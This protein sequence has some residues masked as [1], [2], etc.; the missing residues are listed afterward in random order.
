MNEKTLKLNEEDIYTLIAGLA[1]LINLDEDCIKEFRDDGMD[2]AKSEDLLRK[3][4][5]LCR[6]LRELIA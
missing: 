5:E 1:C 6:K 2:T 4:K 3:E